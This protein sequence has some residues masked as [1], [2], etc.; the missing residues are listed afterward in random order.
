V[1]EKCF[2]R[3]KCVLIREDKLIA[4]CLIGK[5]FKN[6]NKKKIEEETRKYYFGWG[7]LLCKRPI[8]E[9]HR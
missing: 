7:I 3:S 9:I 6:I 8:F 2:Y 5:C 4:T 1:A